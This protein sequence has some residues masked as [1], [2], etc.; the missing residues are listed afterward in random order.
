MAFFKY[1]G[2]VKSAKVNILN[3]E[4][5]KEVIKNCSANPFEHAKLQNAPLDSMKPAMVGAQWYVDKDPAA[6]QDEN[7]MGDD[8]DEENGARVAYSLT[9]EDNL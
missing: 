1:F 6:A 4:T 7:Y 9:P 5:K 2:S 8:D 3:F